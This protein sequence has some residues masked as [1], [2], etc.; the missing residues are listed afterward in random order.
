MLQIH[1]VSSY[2]TLI[3][4]PRTVAE[5]VVTSLPG[6]TSD[7]P[8]VQSLKPSPAMRDGRFVN[9]LCTDYAPSPQLAPAGARTVCHIGLPDEALTIPRRH[10]TSTCLAALMS[11]P[12]I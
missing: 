12:L 4:G 3:Y 7:L 5:T 2:A 11:V 1:R 6:A 10:S 8:V 9:F